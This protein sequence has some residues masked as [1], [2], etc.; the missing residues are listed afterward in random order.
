M[1]TGE[2]LLPVRAAVAPRA[3]TLGL[4]LGAVAL[5][6]L[7]CSL[8]A[9]TPADAIPWGSCALAT[10]CAAL[11]GVTAAVSGRSG[12]G[13]AQWK[14]GAWSL[15]W[16]AV[17]FGLA[18]AVWSPV[19]QNSAAQLTPDSILR[20]LWLVAVAMTAW[21]VGYCTGPRKI[22][23]RQAARLTSALAARFGPSVRSPAVPWILYAVGTAARLATV[24]TTGRLGYVGDAAAAVSTASGY[25]QLL[26]LAGYRT[27]RGRSRCPARLPRACSACA[28]DARDPVRRRSGIRR[29]RRR[30]EP[31]RNGGPR[32]GHPVHRGAAEGPQGAAIRG[33]H[34]IPCRDHPVRGRIPQFRAPWRHLSLTPRQGISGHPRCCVSTRRARRSQ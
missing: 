14:L 25:Q 28:P 30:Q 15:A 11:L 29:N 3:L 5:V 4:A 23:E 33:G 8:A 24:G 27:T 16:C 19:Q 7:G 1:S 20:G 10:W 22:A 21:S 6:L 26:A 34:R 12:V 9:P 18:T 13:L 2:L 17:T 32:R 31:V